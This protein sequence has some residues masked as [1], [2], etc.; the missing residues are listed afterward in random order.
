MAL[1][2]QAAFCI[3]GWSMAVIVTY[4]GVY[5][6][7]F[8]RPLPPTYRGCSCTHQRKVDVGGNISAAT[9]VKSDEASQ[10]PLVNDRECVFPQKGI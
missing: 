1:D 9:Q 2:R 6:N 3:A 10:K 8:T 7:A 4:Y 5:M